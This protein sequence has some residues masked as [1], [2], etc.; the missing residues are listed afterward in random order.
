MQAVTEWLPV[1]RLERGPLVGLPIDRQVALDDDGIGID[2]RDLAG[3]TVIHRDGVWLVA[4]RGALDGAARIVVDAAAFDLAEVHVVHGRQ[5]TQ[6]LTG[7]AVECGDTEVED[8]IRRAR[9]EVFEACH[10]ESVVGH[11]EVVGNRGDLH[12]GDRSAGWESW[13]AHV[14]SL[15]HVA[16]SPLC[17][18]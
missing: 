9:F 2:G 13:C 11:D 16:R 17:I 15:N 7:W 4:G 18:Q 6:Q 14:A 5:T 10:D 3:R 8:P 12:G 1:T